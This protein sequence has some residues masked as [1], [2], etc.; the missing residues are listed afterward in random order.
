MTGGGSDR[1]VHFPPDMNGTEHESW[2]SCSIRRRPTYLC[3]FSG[4]INGFSSS[5]SVTKRPFARRELTERNL[6]SHGEE[7]LGGGA[8]PRPLGERRVRHERVQRLRGDPGPSAPFIHCD[9]I[10]WLWLIMI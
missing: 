2:G 1:N 6:L 7:Q 4:F 5:K 9:A 3:Q 10:D 8:R